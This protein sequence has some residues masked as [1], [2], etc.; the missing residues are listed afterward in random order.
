MKRSKEAEEVAEAYAQQP[1][2]DYSIKPGEKITIKLD[3]PKRVSGAF[4]LKPLS[5]NEAS[6]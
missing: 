6:A 5:M 1:S 3:I 4:L 2:K